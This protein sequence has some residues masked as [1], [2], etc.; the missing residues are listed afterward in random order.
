MLRLLGNKE[1][2]AWF[3]RLNT[4][5]KR[6]PADERRELHA[7]VRQHLEALAAA[8]EELGSLPEEAWEHALTQFGD[9]GKF[10]RRMV[11]EWRRGQGWVSPDMAAVLYG[12]GVHAVASVGFLALFCVVSV[13]DYFFGERI[14]GRGVGWLL[15]AGY[16]VGVPGLTGFKL[17]RK[18]PSQASKSALHTAF[19]LPILPTLIGLIAA[20]S[21]GV[22]YQYVV[23]LVS[24]LAVFSGWLLLTCGAAYLASVTKRGWYRPSW[25]DFKIAL[26]KRRRQVG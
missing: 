17:G 5:L 21:Q 16:F 9:P 3:Q 6:L 7:E 13:L 25:A 15:T 1:L 12:C 8:N 22:S 23:I 2:D 14:L 11:W 10:A 4:P 20:I 19:V 26:P 18:Y 24:F